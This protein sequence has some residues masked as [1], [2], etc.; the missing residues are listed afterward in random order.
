MRAVHQRDL[1]TAILEAKKNGFDVLEIHLSAP[2]FLPENYKL[3]ELKK[4][5][6]FSEEHNITLQTHSEIGQSLIQADSISRKAEKEKLRLTVKFSKHIGARNLT[7]HVGKAPQYHL[8][9]GKEIRNELLYEKYY[10]SLF[11]DSIKYI[12]SIASRELNIC[13]ENDNLLPGFQKILDKYLKLGKVFLTY[14][15]IKAS[16]EQAKF[17]GRNI[18]HI[19]NVHVSGIRHGTL[20]GL[21]KNVEKFLKPLDNLNLPVIIEIVSTKEA[22]LGKSI[23]QSIR[24]K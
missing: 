3:S 23:I 16:K 9:P 24:S 4:L 17:F 10:C 1:Y 18:R 8:G 20:K 21:E 19:R 11:E 12:T 2:Q 7:L 14:D 22:I 6:R 5:R 13:I 15:F